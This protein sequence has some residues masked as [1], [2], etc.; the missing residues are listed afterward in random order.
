M[1][2][3]VVDLGCSVEG[4]GLKQKAALTVSQRLTALNPGVMFKQDRTTKEFEEVRVQVKMEVVTIEL[5]LKLLS[6]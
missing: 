1:S 6:S 4:R 3:Q 5:I 2:S